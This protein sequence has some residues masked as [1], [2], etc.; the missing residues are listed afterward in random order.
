MLERFCGKTNL[1]YMFPLLPFLARRINKKTAHWLPAVIVK[2]HEGSAHVDVQGLPADDSA[3][4]AVGVL[5]SDAER[6]VSAALQGRQNIGDAKSSF[7]FDA[8]K[9]KTKFIPSLANANRART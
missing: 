4:K 9:D 1:R 5:D 2:R 8:T 3:V 7:A 6:H